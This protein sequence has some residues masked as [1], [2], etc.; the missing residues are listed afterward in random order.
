ML[1]DFLHQS[2]PDVI[3]GSMGQPGR[4]VKLILSAALRAEP[5]DQGAESL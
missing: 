3:S 4:F 1:L 2:P 5:P